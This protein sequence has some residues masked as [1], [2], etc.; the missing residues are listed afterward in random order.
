MIAGRVR[1]RIRG[2]AR[3]IAGRSGVLLVVSLIS[4]LYLHNH[5]LIASAQRAP[6]VLDHGIF[7]YDTDDTSDS[8]A[9]MF[10]QASRSS[11]VREA[12]KAQY[13]LG[14]YYHKKYEIYRHS[15]HGTGDRQLLERSLKAYKDYLNKFERGSE[16]RDWLSDVRFDKALVYLEMDNAPMA[17]IT[18][19]D[20]NP[21]R[22][23][24]IYIH[25]IVWSDDASDVIDY[26]VNSQDLKDFTRR[27]LQKHI[28]T[29]FSDVSFA[30]VVSE[31]KSW[32]VGR[33]LGRKQQFQRKGD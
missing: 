19:R 31:L 5:P 29:R 21:K 11:D 15:K 32:C 16:R 20:M 24:S 2:I 3:S 22:D 17:D 18:L 9:M 10:L 33:K 23:P 25:Q 28:G 12:E 26:S 7:L 4:T 13:Y 30:Q 8:A 27:I 14:R 1:S 6:Q